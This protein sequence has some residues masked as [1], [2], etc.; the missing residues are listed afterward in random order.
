VEQLVPFAVTRF[1][2]SPA[3]RCMDTVAPAAAAG[4]MK[5]DQESDLA[6]G[7]GS[8][9]LTLVRSLLEGTE[10]VVLC[11]HGDVIGDVL[12]ELDRTGARLGS[13]DRC[14]KGSAW[15]LER[16]GDGLIQGRYVPPP[17]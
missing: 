11:T 4:G 6:E 3:V 10:D 16:N 15:V 14:Q 17:Q 12:D 2:S 5:V 8:A 13:A 9:A 7:R 1:L